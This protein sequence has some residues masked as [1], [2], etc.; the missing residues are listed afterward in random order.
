MDSNNQTIERLVAIF[1]EL[2]PLRDELQRDLD[3]K[4]RLEINYN[5]NHIEGNTLTYSETELLLLFDKTKGNHEYREYEEMKA[6]DVAFEMVKELAKEPDR[7][8]TEATIKNLNKILLVRPYWKEAITD[9]GQPTKRLIDVGDYKKYPNHVRLKNGEKF[10]YAS[11]EETPIKMGE[12]MEWLRSTEVSGEISPVELAA[13]LHYKFVLIHPFDD[14]NG[15]ISRLLMNYVL[16]KNGLQPAVIRSDDKKA[17]LFALNQADTGDLL[18]FVDYI[19]KCE[20]SALELAI[21]AAKGESLEEDD[22][23]Q[24]E[25]GIWKRGVRIQK[26]ELPHRNDAAVYDLFNVGGLANIFN[27]F[28]LRH[29]EFYELFEGHNIKLLKLK[30][31]GGISVLNFEASNGDIRNALFPNPDFDA[32]EN[33][34]TFINLLLTVELKQYKFN[35]GNAFNVNPGL[36][37]DFEPYRYRMLFHGVTLA[38]KKYG[39]YLSPEEQSLIFK[40]AVNW[41]FDEIKQHQ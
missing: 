23:L 17:Y 3:K 12:L 35:P 14:G 10:Y 1:K 6:H 18:P 11:P 22:D 8:L 9:D 28:I 21:R 4:I 36:S 34:D 37:A 2:S 19:G 26:I 24:K 5:S 31:V 41:T 30:V 29:Q 27:Q 40:K 32:R 38:E 7:P 39:E 20:S 15:R 25:I 16:L 13:V 33:L